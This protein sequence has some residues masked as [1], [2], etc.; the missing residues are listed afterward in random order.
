MVGDVLENIGVRTGFPFG[1]Y[2]FTNVMGPKLSVVPVLLALAYVGM[3]YLSWI[4]ACSIMGGFHGRLLGHRRIT[5]P[6]LA[7]SVMV[8]WDLSQDPVWSTI[9]HAWIWQQ[10]GPYFGVPPSNF[11]GWFL[12]VYIIFQLFAV[13]LLRCSHPLPLPSR[14]Y[15]RLA[16]LFYAISAAGNLLLLLP[17]KQPALVSDA[18]GIWWRVNNITEACAL[19]TLLTM[20]AFSAVGWKGTKGS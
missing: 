9:L 6:L 8:S 10:G 11:L 4:V 14:S 18:A 15:L 13:Y 2:H 19:V 12:T 5:L 17:N 3:A 1:R 20:G 16:I 7:A